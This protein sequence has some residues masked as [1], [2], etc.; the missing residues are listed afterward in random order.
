MKNRGLTFTLKQTDINYRSRNLVKQDNDWKHK[1][2][3]TVKELDVKEGEWQALEEIL[4]KAISRLSVA[5]RGIDNALDQQLKNIQQFSR[6][7]QDK[8]LLE[9]L[10]KLT[11][12]IASLDGDYPPPGTSSPAI[13]SFE[14]SSVLLEM[15]QDIKL[16]Q[17]QTSALKKV[18]AD[19]LRLIAKGTD[20]RSIEPQVALLSQII[21][22][23]L[24]VATNT[25]CIVQPFLFQLVSL[26]E[27]NDDNQQKI[28]LQL[29]LKGELTDHQLQNLADI[30][31]SQLSDTTELE[32]TKT[33]VPIDVII[34]SL[35]E[36]LA[37][38]QGAS[39]EIDK[40]Q[41]KIEK[42]IANAEWPDTLNDIVNSVSLALQKL[43]D[44]KSELENFILT[45]TEQLGNITNV[46]TKDFDEQASGW[47]DTLSLQKLV[48]SGIVTIKENVNVVQ[49]ITQLKA[50]V[51]DNIDSIRDGV[52]S[53]LL[54]ANQRFDATETHKEELSNK[55]AHMEQ[56]TAKLQ[57][58]LAKNRKKLLYDTLTGVHS[59]LAY[60]EQIIRELSRWDRYGTP[61][62]Y[63]ILDIDHF[64]QV[65][66]KYGHNA[67]DK[68]LRLIAQ[69]M[70]KQIRKSDTLFRI[71]GEEFVLL[72]TNT[73]LAKAEPLITKLRH[74]VAESGFH[75]KQE[76][77]E[78]TLS[79][80]ITEATA[81]DSIQ[82]I[83]ERA[84]AALYKAKDAGRNCQF[85]A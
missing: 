61:F 58:K 55:I 79:A 83:Y 50:A 11:N 17:K 46:I 25:P 29:E 26:L 59:R 39:S 42:G 9:S 21:N 30:I 13:N 72:L 52:E 15:L 70:Q 19:L 22:N 34:C 1:Y 8:K 24:I 63:A 4:R 45:V 66:D 27:L 23:G 40:I 60:N 77:V 62:S 14:P 48:Q 84:D 81:E 38:V 12:I 6:K 56:E 5:G 33:G 32:G 3:V 18:C 69:L 44:E 54:R 7:K 36:R 64:K 28:G 41:T 53:F 76:R 85:I 16:G 35:L 2:Q 57:Q 43:S 78:L 10:E 65:N 74:G 82:S 37:I 73:S 31:N 71:G 49:D 67:G 68:A 75:F 51:G 47:S 20:L 80:G